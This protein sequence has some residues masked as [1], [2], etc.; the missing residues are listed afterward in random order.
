MRVHRL[1]TMRAQ[2]HRFSHFG[3]KNDEFRGTQKY[4]F[5]SDKSAPEMFNTFFRDSIHVG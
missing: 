1:R 2:K 3:T 5:G 4:F